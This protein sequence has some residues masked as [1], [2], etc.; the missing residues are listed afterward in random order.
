MKYRALIA[1]LAALLPTGAAGVPLAQQSISDSSFVV[2][3]WNGLYSGMP[4]TEVAAAL[5]AQGKN[6]RAVR[7]D[8]GVETVELDEMVQVAGVDFEPVFAFASRPS[9]LFYVELTA[10]MSCMRTVSG[11][12]IQELLSNRY[13][14]PHTQRDSQYLGNSTHRFESRYSRGEVVV[15][16]AYVVRYSIGTECSRQEG[17]SIRYWQKSNQIA[18]ERQE[19]AARAAELRREG[20]GL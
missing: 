19:A 20:E 1:T 17:Y 2:Q 3:L 14:N 13:G 6:P 12:R 4:A 8:S 16:F 15:D 18:L 9:G 11:A 5:R 7:S 10:G